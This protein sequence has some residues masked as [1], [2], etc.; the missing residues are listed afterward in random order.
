VNNLDDLVLR[1]L[2]GTWMVLYSSIM[3][4]TTKCTRF[5]F[6]VSNSSSTISLFKKSVRFDGIELKMMGT[7]V[8]LEP[9]SFYANYPAYPGE[10]GMF[11]KN[12][13]GMNTK[14]F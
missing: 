10:F 13:Q 12:L 4:S 3:N 7:A 8:E 5:V 2:N 1:N 9:G 11:L 14:I 6:S